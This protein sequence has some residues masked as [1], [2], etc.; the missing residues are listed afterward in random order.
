[1]RISVSKFIHNKVDKTFTA[2]SSN[3][4]HGWQDGVTLVTERGTTASF[5]M[6]EVHYDDEG[7]IQYWTLRCD[8]NPKALDYTM[9]VFND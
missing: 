9:V 5:F 7:D 8:S 1:M 3:L 6:K 4:D 2:E